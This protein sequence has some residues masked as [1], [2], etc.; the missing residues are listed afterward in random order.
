MTFGEQRLKLYYLM[1]NI[2]QDLL[3]ISNKYI[4]NDLALSPLSLPSRPLLSSF[5][6]SLPLAL[7]LLFFRIFIF[8]TI[9]GD[10]ES[11]GK[12]VTRDGHRIN[13]Y[14]TGPVIWGEPG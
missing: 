10:M 12:S 7:C 9:K 5:L 11:N 1:I 2:C 6:S 4:S 14:K 8:S 13:E 3:L